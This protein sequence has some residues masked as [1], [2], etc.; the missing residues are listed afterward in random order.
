VGVALGYP[1]GLADPLDRTTAS[2]VEGQIT[3]D[4][5]TATSITGSSNE[6]VISGQPP[7]AAEV[8][9]AA[10]PSLAQVQHTR[11]SS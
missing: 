1:S 4:S 3:A 5:A 8:T 10:F 9:A 6:R 7:T 11:S 2:A